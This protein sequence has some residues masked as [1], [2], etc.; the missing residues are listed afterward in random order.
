M[1]ERLTEEE[2]MLLEAL[3]MSENRI[4]T[5]AYG[6]IKGIPQQTVCYRKNALLKKLKKLLDEVW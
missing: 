2:Q 1:F 6:Q 4:T 5:T 3:I